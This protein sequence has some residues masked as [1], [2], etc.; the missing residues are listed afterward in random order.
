MNN[1]YI[2]IYSSVVYAEDIRQ[3]ANLWWFKI[4]SPPVSNAVI[5]HPVLLHAVLTAQDLAK[6]QVPISEVSKL[7]GTFPYSTAPCFPLLRL[8]QPN[9]TFLT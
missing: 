6:A 9:N 1:Y 8:M 2:A 4:G 3:I 5:N 7:N